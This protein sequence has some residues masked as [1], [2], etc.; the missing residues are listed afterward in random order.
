MPFSLFYCYDSVALLK[1]SNTIVGTWFPL[2]TTLLSPLHH[3]TAHNILQHYYTPCTTVHR[4]IYLLPNDIKP[5][6]SPKEG[7]HP[8]ISNC[9]KGVLTESFNLCVKKATLICYFTIF[10]C[11]KS[12]T[13]DTL[14]SLFTN[15]CELLV[16]G[17]KTWGRGSNEK[18]NTSNCST[19]VSWEMGLY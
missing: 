8:S 16:H 15:H 18:S 7:F 11:C 9:Q 12:R 19:Y 13:Y 1:R 17:G 14:Q 4:E 2:I 5:I 6:F 3:S 10:I